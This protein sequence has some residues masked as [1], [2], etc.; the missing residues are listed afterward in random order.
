MLCEETAAV[1]VPCFAQESDWSLIT[2]M[3]NR[4]LGLAMI[5]S[6]RPFGLLLH[7]VFFS[8]SGVW[9][10]V[11]FQHGGEAL[12]TSPVLQSWYT[13][14]CRSV[15]L[16]FPPFLLFG[17]LTGNMHCT[18]DWRNSLCDA[19]QD[20][21]VATMQHSSKTAKTRYTTCEPCMS[22]PLLT[23]DIAPFFLCLILGFDSISKYWAWSP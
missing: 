9:S 18:L 21:C 22:L 12:G 10:F 17:V 16:Y 19:C 14:A 20:R 2:G 1:A 4:P 3:K 5:C 7:K 8:A 15:N 23:M 11:A 13:P 6:S